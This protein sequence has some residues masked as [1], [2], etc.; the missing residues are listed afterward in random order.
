M[1]EKVDLKPCPFCGSEAFLWQWNG[2]TAIQCSKFNANSH[3]IQ[4]QAKVFEIAVGRWNN[5]ASEV[6]KSDN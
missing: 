2:G 4:V 5:R 6:V 3:V 1:D